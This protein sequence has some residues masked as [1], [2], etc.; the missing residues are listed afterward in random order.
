MEAGITLEPS[1][2]RRD[3]LPRE[4]SELRV[5]V[6][7]PP[8]V[9]PFQPSMTLPYLVAQLRGLGISA[10]SHNLSSLF[11][12]WLFRRIRLES[13]ESY[14]FLSTAMAVLRDPTR[15]F[16][17]AAY[18]SA[19]ERLEDYVSDLAERDHLPYSLYPAS[20]ASAVA[21]SGNYRE[22]VD[23]MPGT[24]LESFLRDYVG[25]TLRLDIY[26]VI[27]FSAT[28][29]FQLGSSLFIGR[30]LKRAGI[31][32]HLI[33]GGHAVSVA[34]RALFEDRELTG[35]ID[36]VVFDGGADV[37][38]TICGDVVHSSVRRSY[39]SADAAAPIAAKG[40]FP[41]DTPYRVV[42]QQ[43]INDLYL[44]P[45]QMFSIYSALGCSYG[46]CTFCGSNRVMAP[47]VPR[48]ISVLVDEMEQL[49]Q[50]YGIS[51]FDIC[52]NNFDPDRAAEFCDELERRDQHFFWQCTSRVYTTLT[53]P[54]LQRM[55]RL[56]C[57]LMNIGLESAS[58]RIL[59]IMRK[60]YTADHVE[61]LLAN[62]EAADMPVHLYCICSF[63]SETAAE[64]E[65]TLHFLR[66]HLHR[67]HSVYFQNY[68]AQ[69]ASKIFTSDL[70]TATEGY[71]SVH[72]I[73]ALLS[74]PQLAQDYVA[75]GN[76]VRR[77][78]YPF[79]EGHNFL[80]LAHEEGQT[81]ESA[82]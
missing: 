47:Y 42:L 76:L 51:H 63:P 40:L 25:F 54:L 79:I 34:G 29:A 55:R 8:L 24:L 68:E 32:A 35:C 45:H 30:M 23:A 75:N 19:L 65:K 20:R 36:S 69:L 74:D 71:D 4:V 50:N 53:V 10:D 70:G 43:D 81:K 21:D 72:M 41:T 31:P 16:D 56:G 57:A 61:D 38:A 1:A 22:L 44:S 66:R 13:M 27:G 28:N 58:D 49:Q 52:D 78:G 80:Y 5:A 14:R 6:F 15:F 59:K 67:C 73:D 26:D 17:P 62:T 77:H 33:L 48:T 60:G 9:E 11:Y 46:A 2:Y 37:F 18:H 3:Q 7:A 82:S 12:I 64:S 39:S